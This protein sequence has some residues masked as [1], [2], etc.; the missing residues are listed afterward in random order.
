[1]PTLGERIKHL[2]ELKG[3]SQ[4]ELS[5]KTNLTIVQLSRYENN[6]R[7]PDPDALCR[8]VNVLGTSA[9]YLIGLTSNPIQ[10]LNE[11]MSFYLD[12]PLHGVFLREFFNAPD[13][14]K[15]ETR[16]FFNFI[17]SSSDRNH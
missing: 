14:L 9:D 12:H 7:K 1:M 2:R 8:L 11:Q 17:M 4:K 16:Q 15:N 5:E 6:H 3:F 13:Q 10:S